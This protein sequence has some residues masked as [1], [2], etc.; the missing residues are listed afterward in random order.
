L[1]LDILLWIKITIDYSVLYTQYA[2]AHTIAKG[3]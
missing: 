1:L 3:C 2:V